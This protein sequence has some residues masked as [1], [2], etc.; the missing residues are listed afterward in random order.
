MA[1]DAFRQLAR[2]VFGRM[3][4]V[5]TQV[6]RTETERAVRHFRERLGSRGDETPPARALAAP[7]AS[8]SPVEPQTEAPAAKAGTPSETR[9][10]VTPPT[11][12]ATSLGET[13]PLRA[14]AKKMAEEPAKKSK[15]EA[16][17]KF[18]DKLEASG[19]A[20]VNVNVASRDALIALPGIGEA[21][22]DAI[23]KGRPFKDVAELQERKILPAGVL[24]SLK[25][26]ITVG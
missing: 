18:K 23:I 1:N 13:A 3:K 19:E 21:R 16:T 24:A 17:P 5:V 25:G 8:S 4:G 10:A 15:A 7:P 9:P 22:A 6:V 20:P 11:P 14:A 26:R 2:A 12:P